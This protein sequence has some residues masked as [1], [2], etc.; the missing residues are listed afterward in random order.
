[1]ATSRRRRDFLAKA[2]A[3]T[4]ATNDARFGS[5][6]SLPLLIK[7]PRRLGNWNR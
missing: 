4:A 5:I 7:H 3:D 2:P 6:I 1:L